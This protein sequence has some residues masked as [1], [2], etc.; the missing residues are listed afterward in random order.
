MEKNEQFR[1]K[2]KGFKQTFSDFDKASKA[3]ESQKSKKIRNE[4]A[5][6]LVLEKRDTPEHEWKM[7]DEVRI[8]DSHYE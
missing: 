8:S 2:T 4:E 7:V 6:T 1:V 3:F 5:F